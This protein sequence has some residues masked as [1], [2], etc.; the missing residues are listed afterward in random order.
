MMRLFG[1]SVKKTLPLWSQVGPSVTLNPCASLQCRARS[2]TGE[3]SCWFAPAR[4]AGAAVI[5]GSKMEG[6]CMAI[7]AGLAAGEGRLGKLRLKAR[8]SGRLTARRMLSVQTCFTS[9]VAYCGLVARRWFLVACRIETVAAL[10][11]TGGCCHN[12]PFQSRQPEP[13]RWASW[14]LW[15]GGIVQEG[16]NARGEI[17]LYDNPDWAKGFDVVVHNDVSPTRR[18]RLYIRK[19]TSAHKAGVPGGGDPLRDAYLPRD[20]HR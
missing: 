15:N 9:G 12:Y 14:Q 17:S 10:L 16:G 13:M 1:W 5:P 7:C 6:D 19:I 11:I 4:G 8:P 20:G 3:K 18:T 2:M